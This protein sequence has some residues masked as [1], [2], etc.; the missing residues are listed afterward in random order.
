MLYE[1]NWDRFRPALKEGW[2]EVPDD[3]TGLLRDLGPHIIDQ[4]LLLFGM[5]DSLTADVAAQRAGS[6]IDDY[7]ELTLHYGSR[8]VC[9]RSS[10]LVAAPRP[11]FSI[12]GTGGSFVKYGLDPQEPQ[13]K[14][15]LRPGDAALGVDTEDGVFTDVSGRTE[16]VQTARGNYLA[17]YEAVAAAILDGAPVPV[18]AE[19]ARDGLLLIDLARDAARQGRRLQVPAAS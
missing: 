16:T 7:F 18:T 17:Y 4:A 13:L 10:S 1:A 2:K 5:P 12:H 6:Q 9:L 14:H 15:G 11:R 8:R 3:T 19:D